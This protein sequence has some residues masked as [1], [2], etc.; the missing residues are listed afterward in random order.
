MAAMGHT[1]NA[2][3]HLQQVAGARGIVEG[4]PGT[5][6][7]AM[8][9]KGTNQEREV[10]RPTTISSV[11]ALHDLHDSEAPTDAKIGLQ[12]EAAARTDVLQTVG[13]TVSAR[14]FLPDLV[15]C[16][17]HRFSLHDICQICGRTRLD[18]VRCEP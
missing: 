6:S 12:D 1:L 16:L 8:S 10:R 15:T 13:A 18:V 9:G 5:P 17:P 7:G 4:G 3:R 14:R 11:P 2:A